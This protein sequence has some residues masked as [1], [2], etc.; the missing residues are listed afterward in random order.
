MKVLF[1]GPL[2]E[3]TTGQS[4]ACRVFLDAVEH[5]HD[6]VVVN[7]SKSTF[8]Q[9]VSS[10]SR[11][12][13][14]V[15]ILLEVRRHRDGAD[16]IYLTI[17]E[18]IAGNLKDLAIYLI[19]RRRLSRVVIHL[20]GGAGIRRILLR[21]GH[22]L[23]RVN[24]FF[25][26]RLGGV[27][28]LGQRHAPL[29][30]HSVS[31]DRL[32]VVPNF[33]QDELFE[34]RERIDAKFHDATPMRVLFLSN[35]LPGKGHVELLEAYR[36]LDESLRAKMRLDYAGGF[37]SSEDESAFLLQ[38]RATPGA[39]YHGTVR[40]EAKRALF[41]QAHVFCLPTYYPYEGQPISILEAYAAG[42]AVIT[43]D[44]SGIG[45]IFAGGVN[46]LQVEPRSP[47]DLRKALEQVVTRVD[48]MRAIALA[49]RDEADRKFRTCDYN[50]RLMAILDSTA[51]RA[52]GRESR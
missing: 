14:V 23:R 43:T 19:C 32:H 45:D 26:R 44:H 38:V 36:S 46:G 52:A 33:A 15:R 25:V 8:R 24:E 35:L 27:I 41:Q 11:I 30:A 49:N 1:I 29:F 9:G 5:K 3:P 18:S 47:S 13:D 31:A 28:V 17:A 7:L 4:L 34:T 16:V 12:V 6:V 40:G 10:L 39:E 22:P 48:G 37:E 42:C 20:H 50:A 21:K 2:P 51:A